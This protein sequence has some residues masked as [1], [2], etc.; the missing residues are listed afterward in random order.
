[1]PIEIIGVFNK[2][3]VMHRVKIPSN[4]MGTKSNFEKYISIHTKGESLLFQKHDVPEM[5]NLVMSLTVAKYVLGE[6]RFMI[7]ELE[8]S[9]V[10]VVDMVDH[11]YVCNELGQAQMVRKFH[12]PVTTFDYNGLWV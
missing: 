8:K 1:M 5:C 3:E 12:E 9:K 10:K 7:N 2:N 11:G 4:A 6:L